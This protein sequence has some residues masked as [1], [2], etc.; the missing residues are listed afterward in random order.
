V[1]EGKPKWLAKGRASGKAEGKA[2]MLLCVLAARDIAITPAI[3]ERVLSCADLAQLETWAAKAVRANS[4][5]DVF[6]R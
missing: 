6:A 5:E 4:V 3:R 1:R 2:E